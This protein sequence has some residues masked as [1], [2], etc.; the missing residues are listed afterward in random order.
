LCHIYT[1][2]AES[3]KAT[4]HYQETPSSPLALAF[5]LKGEEKNSKSYLSSGVP[6]RVCITGE[7]AVFFT[8][9]AS[10]NNCLRTQKRAGLPRVHR[11]F[12]MKHCRR[13]AL[14]EF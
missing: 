14:G 2:R 7:I 13:A 12:V 11:V 4:E 9:M 3:K 10:T 5:I 8:S 6:W 1:K